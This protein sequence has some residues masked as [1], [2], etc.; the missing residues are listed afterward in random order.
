MIGSIWL[1]GIF[2]SFSLHD[3]FT[4]TRCMCQKENKFNYID[5]AATEDGWIHKCSTSYSEQQ[6]ASYKD[7][8]GPVYSVKWC[9]FHPDLFISASADWTVRLW[10]TDRPNSLLTFQTGNHEINDVQW[11]PS[12]STA[13]ATA[14]G[15]GS[16]DVWDM[17]QGTLKPVASFTDA[18]AKMTCVLFHVDNETMIAGDGNGGVT[19]FRLFGVN[20]KSDSD[21]TQQRR[22]MDAM[23]ANVMK[24][25]GCQASSMS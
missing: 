14:T 5:A 7:H 15:A 19:V 12:N 22:L 3:C 24:T 8:M 16:V 25:G 21:E 18:S 4:I 20:R 13:F 2:D 23:D 9:P 10:R 6:L 11:C 17:L 1:V